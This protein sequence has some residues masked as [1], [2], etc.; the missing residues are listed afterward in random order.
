[1][2][3]VDN[4]LISIVQSVSPTIEEQITSRDAKVL[5]SLAS[6]IINHI[7]LT[8]NQSKLLVKILKENSSKILEF[9]SAI[10]ESLA[11]PVWSREFRK[12][13]QI[14][15]FY[16]G[17]NSDQDASLFIEFNFN[18]EYRKLLSGLSK[19]VENLSITA[20]G[21]IN[22]ADLTEK[23]IVI[24]YEALS[25]LD[26]E[27]DETIK[28][29]YKTIK[30][31]SEIDIQNQFLIGNIDYKNFHQAI[32][33]DLGIETSIDHNIINDRSVRYQYRLEDA[34]NSGETLTENIAN[35]SKSKFWISKEKHTLD[36]IIASLVKLH[37]LPLLVVFDTYVNDRYYE[38]LKILSSALENNGIT[39][40][41]GV[42]F[43]LTND[44]SG[45]QF[46][47]FIANKSYNYNLDK[48]TKVAV[49]MSGKLPKFFLRTPWQPMSVI[50]LDTKMG[51]RHGKTSVYS[52][53]CD[54][55][56]EWSDRET[57]MED[58]VIGRW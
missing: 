38:N 16:I 5:R 11:D 40:N 36:E 18:S 45:K 30:S 49:V 23:N 24:L 44:E 3:T 56:I 7:F 17:K 21:K 26:F 31:W 34:K 25:P 33:D 20:A 47:Q 19:Q 50:A 6:S 4:L 43:R 52:N 48:H 39:D 28:N 13:D 10:D 14:K 58:K 42:Y 22:T 54:L 55:I 12:I 46:N 9:T 57:L 1:M 29:Y 53:R 27:I 32:T 35:R 37:R 2:T 8:E 41:I 51:L 15:K